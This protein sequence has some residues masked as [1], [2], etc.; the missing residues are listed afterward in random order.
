MAEGTRTTVTLQEMAKRV[1]GLQ[2]DVQASRS[3]IS[4]MKVLL[5]SFS[6]MLRPPPEPNPQGIG[7]SSPLNSSSLQSE[8]NQQTLDLGNANP[9]PSSSAHINNGG[10]TLP[11]SLVTRLTKIDFP[12]FDGT[13]LRSWLYQ[14]EQFFSL[15]NTVPEFRVRLASVH[16]RGD[17]LEW[18]HNY[19]RER[20]HVYPL[21]SEYVVDVSS[22]F[23]ELIDDPLAELVGIRYTGDAQTYLTSFES[24]LTKLSL[25]RAHSLSIFLANL[26]TQM[27][28]H[29]RQFNP[30]TI[31]QA[32]RLV[33]LQE[34]IQKTN[35]PKPYQSYHS[36]QSHHTPFSTPSSQPS[37]TPQFSPKHNPPLLPTPPPKFQN[38][39]PISEKPFRT[40]TYAEMQDRRSKG[41][42]M[43]CD[44]PYSPGHHL[45]HRKAQIH[46][47]DGDDDE[48]SDTPC[49]E[50]ISGG[51][52]VDSPTE[53][54]PLQISINALTG[55]PQFN[56]M[57]ITG[58]YENRVLNILIDSGSTHNFLD[59]EAAK[60]FGCLLEPIQPLSVSVANGHKI[61]A[62]YQCR[63]FSWR[64][65][66]S[67]FSADVILLPLGCCDLVL[68]IQWLATL[69]PILWDFA[70]LRME[71]KVLG[72]RHVLRGSPHATHKVVSSS[73]LIRALQDNPE[74]A[75]LQIHSATP[76]ISHISAFDTDL[77]CKTDIDAL[78]V[79][80]EEV[81]VA[82]SDLPPFR[83]GFDHRIPLLHGANPVSKR[84]YRYSVIQKDA[85]EEMVSEML[86][87]GTIQHSNSPFAFPVVLV[88]KKD[89][90]W[91]MC[92]DYRELN[93]LTIKDKY[94]IPLL[95]DLL[96]ELGAAKIFSK[97]DLR[98]GFHQIRMHPPDIHKT[99]FKT[100]SG[101]YEYLVMPFGLTN[102]PCTFQSLMNHVFRD[103][104]RRFVLVFFDDILIYSTDWDEHLFHLTSVLQIL[105][106]NQLY[107]KP[108]KCSFGA[109]RIEYLGHF[110]SAEGVSTDPSKIK[111]IKDWPTPLTVKQLRGFLGLANYY[112]R[113]VRGY[114]NIS[115]PLTDLLRKDH[116]VW[117]E[118]ASVAFN[119]LK[120]SLSSS[121]VLALPDFNKPFVVE[122]DASGS[123]IGAVLMQEHHPIAYISRMLSPRQQALSVYEREL[124]A[125]VFAVQKWSSYLMHKH[126]IIKTDQKSLKFLLDQAI[127]TPFQH[128]WI[129]K[130][131]GYNYEIQYKQGKENV[132]A[133]ALSRATHAQL[134]QLHLQFNNDDLLQLIKTS[135]EDDPNTLKLIQELK[136]DP[137]SHPKFQ[138]TNN[139]LRRGTKLVVGDD[140]ILKTKLLQWLHDS[141]LGGHSGR[142]STTKRV[143][144]IF[145]WKG[146]HKEV[147][148]YV[149]NCAIC[150]RNKYDTSASPGLLQPLPIPEAVWQDISL[151]FVE[152]LPLSNGKQTV[153][154]VID[155][156]SK[157]AHFLPLKHP[158]TAIDVAQ[159]YLDNV[160][161]LHGFPK[162][163]V[164]DRDTIFLS[165]VWKDLF[166]LQGVDLKFSTAYH[167]QSDGQTE[168][169]N[170]T[171]E[172]YLRCMCSEAPHTWCKFLSLAEYWYNTTTHTAI[173]LTP[174]EIL[175]GQPPPIHLPYLPGESKVI[176]VDRT[177][178]KR[179]EMIT[180]LKY[181]LQRAQH[182]MTQLAN[183]KRSDREFTLGD[184]VYLKLQPYRQH[185]LK[186][187]GSQKLSARFYG[188]Y[189]VVD[190]VGKVA[191]RLKLPPEAKIHDVFHASQLKLCPNPSSTTPTALPQY[192]PDLGFDKEPEAI[193]ERQYVKRGK[194]AATRV[195]IKWKDQ[196]PE[197]ATWEFYD[198]LLK[199]FPSFDP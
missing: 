93:N 9:T 11:G 193:L 57:K 199:K 95:E 13:S 78:L 8:G 135:W 73:N 63:N 16:F 19:I 18:H 64:I 191:Y 49:D 127:T 99:A 60:L 119:Q 124:L 94:P 17:A 43:F 65:G 131:L 116:F 142:D 182:R 32:A 24:A 163:V 4:E 112:R 187:H 189:M 177:L 1:D 76:K 7:D 83:Q 28:L 31:H 129:A 37:T 151:D 126:F 152:G 50:E 156:L 36:R 54:S 136:N 117:S 140:P 137:S 144:Q 45:K 33:K 174:F 69:G 97:L 101:H 110:I 81:M 115:R 113:F 195:L 91:R 56:T 59:S 132:A 15:D 179:E 39:K 67:S 134:L 74:L 114:G 35:H 82:P 148:N 171:L 175:Y 14:C 55:V 138:W 118:A 168:V 51:V 87:A 12:K 164:S 109:T 80:F 147:K 157:Y 184:W 105:Q 58:Y 161:K 172:T 178:R 121:P 108:S 194:A 176:M 170:R 52:M 139:E 167:P 42:C 68:G 153:L 141:S 130:L 192:L 143:K 102:A 186:G 133:D 84:P 173:Q 90:T 2:E 34:G 183:K 155:R 100:H 120:Q 150:Q 75:M 149:R 169:T 48:S 44:E 62:S 23:C 181:H 180:L 6:A 79:Q 3:D 196:P 21:W 190:K 89:N 159:A 20:N 197:L 158:Y 162:S 103:Q 154:V 122:T 71:F 70:H 61:G 66:Q 98:A 10:Q 111:V 26:S 40:L 123:G 107:L 41:L 47:L 104:L 188:P 96:D 165:E 145:Y 22:R 125:V 146:L 160:F 72:K 77:S 85:I 106:H 30:T 92:V 46:L 53:D 128:M 5:Q 29:V 38:T 86:T 88:K 185:S 166:K 27:Q 198:E 25:S